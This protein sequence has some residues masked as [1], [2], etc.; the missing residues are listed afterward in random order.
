MIRFSNGAWVI[1]LLVSCFYYVTAKIGFEF[2]LQPGS[3]FDPL[4]AHAVLMAGLLLTT[5]RW[6]LAPY[7]R[8]I[9]CPPRFRG[10]KRRPGNNGVLV[11]Y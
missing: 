9:S 3:V 1:A 5:R 2:A 4:D 8:G 7:R 6:W 11:V 10:S